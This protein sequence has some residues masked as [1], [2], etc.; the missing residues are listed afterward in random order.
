MTRRGRRY[1]YV[2]RSRLPIRDRRFPFGGDLHRAGVHRI[3]GARLDRLHIDV[4]RRAD[5]GM[6]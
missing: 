4:A 1:A 6:A 3:L 2:D 5:A